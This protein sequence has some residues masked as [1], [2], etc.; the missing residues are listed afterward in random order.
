MYPAFKS[1]RY[2]VVVIGAGSAGVSAAIAAARNGARTLLLDSGPTVGGELLSGLPI[3]GAL[4]A[5]GE[6][7]VGGVMRELLD[8]CAELGGYI[9]EVFDWRLNYG[10]C[11]DPEIMKIVLMEKLAQS[12]VTV[13]LYTLAQEP[14]VEH[15]RVLGV[16]ATNKNGR[17]FIQADVFID[18]SGDG[19]V[20]IAAGAPYEAG[21]RDGEMQPASL[22]FRMGGVSYEKYLRYMR[23]N[24]DQFILAENP[25]IEKTPAECAAAVYDKGLPFCVLDANGDLMDRAISSGRLFDTT[26]VYMWPTSLQRRE[27]GLNTTRLAKLDATDI[28]RL[29]DSLSTLT[30]QVARATSFLRDCVPGF[31]DAHLSGI[32]PRVGIRE[33]RRVMGDYVLTTEDVLEGRKSAEGVAKGS[34]HV[35]LHGAGREQERIPVKDGRSY[36]IPFGS[37]V[38]RNLSNLLVAGRCFSSTREA[39]GSARVMG[40]CMAMGQAAGTAGA[41]ASRQGLPDVRKVAVDSLRERIASQGGVVDGTH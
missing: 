23:D 40:P 2:D 30:D 11:F 6:W 10:V 18:C 31:E 9:G 19:D 24:P 29:S 14:I 7:I 41:L 15:G 34:H 21:G 16:L 13:L 37:L 22:I 3:D 38:P 36:D 4:N 8:A 20:S 32:A 26:A 5:R 35:D 1:K 12:R 27:V 17:T 33:T 28:E 25:I 39:N